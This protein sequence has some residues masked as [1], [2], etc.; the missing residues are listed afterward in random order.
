M[1]Q[2]ALFVL[3][4]A[5]AHLWMSWGVKPDACVGL[6]IGEYVAAC[7]AGVLPLDAG[8]RLAAL[9]GRLM[10]A[11]EEAPTD[12]GMEPLV[13]AAAGVHF[14]TARIPYLSSVTGRW[15]VDAQIRIPRYWG[16]QTR[17]PLRLS[18]DACEFLRREDR[19]FLELGPGPVLGRRI[20]GGGGVCV[21]AL[22]ESA[23]EVPELPFMLAALGR[24]WLS[25]ARI[26]WS[27]F[28]AHERRRRVPLPTYPFERRRFAVTPPSLSRAATR[29]AGPTLA[30][31]N[32]DVRDWFY[33]PIWTQAPLPVLLAAP[34]PAGP[35]GRWLVFVDEC[36]VGQRI[37]DR[38]EHEG[39]DVS[40]VVPGGRFSRPGS[41]TTYTD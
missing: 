18:P 28:H 3:E 22:P 21:E 41:G 1:I 13:Q 17:A 15:I 34:T 39:H 25:G 2:P 24:L 32:S 36:G 7:L 35:A 37:A 10:Q 14:E 40:T 6:G 5:L 19:A 8:L 38:L 12:D 16:R 29:A 20:E 31:R 9:R 26:D 4:Y 27:G 30:T 11:A 33:A 23:G